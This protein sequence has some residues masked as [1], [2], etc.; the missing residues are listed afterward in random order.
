MFFHLSWAFIFVLNQLA[1]A[2]VCGLIILYLRNKPL[3]FQTLFDLLV[4]DLLRTVIASTSV[5]SFVLA[6]SQINAAF[7]DLMLLRN[8]TLAQLL[9]LAFYFSYLFLTLHLTLT[10]IVRIISVIWVGYLVIT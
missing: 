1:I 2:F 9:S 6:L 4:Q 3:G 8:E 10:C 5:S 7:A